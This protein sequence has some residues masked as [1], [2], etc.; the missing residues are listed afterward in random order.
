M[1][2]FLLK[3]LFLLDIMLEHDAFTYGAL[4]VCLLTRFRLFVDETQAI[5]F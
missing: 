1:R 5:T 4:R 3:L 2:R